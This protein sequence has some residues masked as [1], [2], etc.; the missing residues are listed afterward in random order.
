VDG[1]EE[2][3]W[4]RRVASRDDDDGVPLLQHVNMRR[5]KQRDVWFQKRCI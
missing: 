4:Q 5:E 2:D 1:Y 3:E